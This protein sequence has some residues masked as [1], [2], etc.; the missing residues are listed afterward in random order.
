MLLSFKSQKATKT[1]GDK[2]PGVLWHY[3]PV[4]LKGGGYLLLQTARF[5]DFKGDSFMAGILPDIF[6]PDLSKETDIV[7]NQALMWVLDLS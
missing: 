6:V 1:F 5:S 4:P 2:T 3:E 7:L